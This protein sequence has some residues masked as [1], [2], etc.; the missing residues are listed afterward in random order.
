MEKPARCNGKRPELRSA[1]GKRSRRDAKADLLQL[2]GH[3]RRFL[4]WLQLAA[5]ADLAFEACIWDGARPLKG[6]IAN[7]P[8]G[9]GVVAP[10][11]HDSSRAS[12]V[13]EMLG[14][15]P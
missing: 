12:A 13:G 14:E 7:R 5:L 8:R 1:A 15:R 9:Y 11:R 2:D 4:T 10:A 6:T 3:G